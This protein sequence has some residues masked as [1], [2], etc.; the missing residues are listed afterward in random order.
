MFNNGRTE[1]RSGREEQKLKY[2]DPV[3]PVFE[4]MENFLF[5]KKLDEEINNIIDELEF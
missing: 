1:F 4:P 5:D 3:R 2:N